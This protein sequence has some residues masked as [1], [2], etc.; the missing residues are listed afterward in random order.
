MELTDKL[1]LKKDLP[2]LLVDVPPNMA[3]LFAGYHPHGDTGS[4]MQVLL[5]VT[6]ASELEATAPLLLNRL[7]NNALLWII[8]PKKG[9]AIPTD[10]NRDTGWE[11]VFSLGYEP[12][13]S[14]AVDE[15]WTALRFKKKEQIT[16]YIRGIPMEDRQVEGIDFKNRTVT[17]P[18][19]A[20]QAVQ[21]HVGMEAFFNALAFSHK[22][23][24]VMAIADAKKPETR[25]ARIV[26]MVAM[27][28]TKMKEKKNK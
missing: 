18:A 24:H 28:Q 14:V 22:K 1:K 10:L 26:K 27:L 17:L 5:F 8:Y 7:G 6:Q 11:A 21:G 16:G 2:L 20:W 19:D 4:V 25:A 12:V 15:D 13:A 3:A 9:S 23:E